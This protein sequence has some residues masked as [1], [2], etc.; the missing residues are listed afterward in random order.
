MSGKIDFS[1]VGKNFAALY[2]K[3]S[4]TESNELYTSI[5]G[6]EDY[7]DS[8]NLKISDVKWSALDSNLSWEYDYILN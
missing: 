5:D 8:A 2:G 1:K 4:D 7:T 6:Y 3:Q